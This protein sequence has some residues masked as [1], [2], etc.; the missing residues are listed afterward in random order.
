[1]AYDD[2][3]GVDEV[4]VG[5]PDC[6]ARDAVLND[7][8]GLAGHRRASCELSSLQPLAERRRHPTPLSTGQLVVRLA[9]NAPALSEHDLD[10]TL[11]DQEREC[12]P[13]RSTGYRV[14]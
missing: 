4:L 6:V 2:C 11:V 10:Q 8:S 5:T 13:D 12:R 9:H 7:Q 1:M 3:A 14:L